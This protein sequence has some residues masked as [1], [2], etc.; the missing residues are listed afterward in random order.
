MKDEGS[1]LDLLQYYYVLF[2]WVAR[3]ITLRQNNKGHPHVFTPIIL[4][5]GFGSFSDF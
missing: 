3:G 5:L 1:V 2:G 4:Y